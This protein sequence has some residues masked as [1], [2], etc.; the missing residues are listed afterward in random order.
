[1]RI[2]VIED[3]DV[4]RT[5]V[6][7]VLEKNGFEVVTAPQALEGEKLAMQSQHDCIILDLALPDKSGLEV[8]ADL[9]EKGVK[10][11]IL[12]LSARKNIDTKV[13]RTLIR[14]R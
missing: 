10:T 2:L 9:R 13:F 5:L 1:M 14:S 11:P 4:V 6:Q 8:C 3:D 7:R 12:I